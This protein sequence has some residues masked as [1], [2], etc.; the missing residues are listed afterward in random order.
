MSKDKENIFKRF[1]NWYTGAFHK[2]SKVSS[3]RISGILMI[4]WALIV[5]TYYVYKSF[6][7]YSDSNAESLI[8]FIIITGAGLLGAGTL[9]EGIGKKNKKENKDEEL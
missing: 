5:A 4:K 1:L 2:D 3:K 6:Q 8:Q 7:G 9:V